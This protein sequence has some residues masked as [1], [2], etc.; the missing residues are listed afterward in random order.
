MHAEVRLA[1]NQETLPLRTRFRAEMNGQ[2]VHDSLYRRPGWTLSYL[3]EVDD[4]P[5]GFGSMAIAGP[6]KEKPTLFEFYL[7]P[8]FRTKAFTLFEAFRAVSSPAFLEVQTNDTTLFVLAC[9]YGK[10]LASEKIV[11]CDGKLTSH[12]GHGASLH[13]NTP[14]EEIARA[15]EERQGGGE[16]FLRLDSSQLAKGGILFHYNPPYGDIYMEVTAAYRRR[17]FGAFLVQE[18]KRVCYEL[19]AI[20]C[21]RCNFDNVASRQTLQ[22]AGFSPFAHILKGSFQPPV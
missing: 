8:E 11:F 20:P 21:A 5:V 15:I 13:C 7:L 18:L 6:W 14:P 4:T 22:R 9:T 17:G 19:G 10:D 1:S 2:I 16:W 3:I 12:A